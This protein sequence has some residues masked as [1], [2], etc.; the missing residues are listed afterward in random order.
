LY[1]SLEAF[2][3]DVADLKKACTGGDASKVGRRAR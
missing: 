2:L 1:R 3:D